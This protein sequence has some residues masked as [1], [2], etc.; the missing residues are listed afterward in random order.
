MILN[1]TN[2]CIYF[3]INNN[4]TINKSDNFHFFI[5]NL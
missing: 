2:L 1:N 5:M 3:L 4:N